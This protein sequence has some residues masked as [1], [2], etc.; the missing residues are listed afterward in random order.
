MVRGGYSGDWYLILAQLQPQRPWMA[1]RWMSLAGAGWEGM[2]RELISQLQ[3]TN[4]FTC[5]VEA[6][7]I[8]RGSVAVLQVTGF[9]SS[10]VC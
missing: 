9:V 10:K 2:R 3:G 5:G 6:G 1:V 7:K 8:C 4:V